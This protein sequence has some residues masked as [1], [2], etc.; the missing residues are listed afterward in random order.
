LATNAANS[1]L[2]DMA[3]SFL[4]VGHRTPSASGIYSDDHRL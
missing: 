4:I 2:N 3:A 1:R